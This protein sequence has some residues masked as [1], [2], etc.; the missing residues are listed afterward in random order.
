MTDLTSIAGLPPTWEQQ[1]AEANVPGTEELGQQTF[2]KLLTTQLQNQDP[3]DPMKNEDFIAQLAQFSSLEE[4]MGIQASLNS[5]YTG[6]AAMNNATMASLLGTEVVAVGN[7]F[8]YAG[9]GDATL[10]FDASEAIEGGSIT[11][12]DESG[13]VVWSDALPAQEQGEGT[14]TWDGTDLDGQP[15]EAGSFTFT[16]TG[17]GEDGE[18]ID[19]TELV[20]GA[21]DEMDYSSGVPLPSIN[22]YS[23]ALSDIIRL[24]SGD[25]P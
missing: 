3:L 25:A 18:V 15:V 22:G 14:Y 5:V 7:G 8:E 2:L 19:V 16:I 10:H 4:L 21:V 23:I 11:V 13:T 17:S 6:I 1:Q 12:K 20:V 24:T 9:E